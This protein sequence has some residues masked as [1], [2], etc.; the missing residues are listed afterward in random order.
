[1]MRTGLFVYPCYLRPA[2]AADAPPN[3][4]LFDGEKVTRTEGL[5]LSR[6][7]IVNL[8]APFGRTTVE[9]PARPC[10]ARFSSIACDAIKGW[11]VDHSSAPRG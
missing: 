2:P 10:I 3:V 8:A 1:M 6:V 11:T 9:T 7:R 5:I 4:A